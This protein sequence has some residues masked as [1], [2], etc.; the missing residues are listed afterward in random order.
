MAKKL[1]DLQ[2]DILFESLGKIFD[3]S[4]HFDEIVHWVLVRTINEMM[5]NEEYSTEMIKGEFK[6]ALI[7][8]LK[9]KKEDI[10]KEIKIVTNTK[11]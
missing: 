1:R 11:D 6:R 2:E 9:M 3:L 10:N 8:A 7:E 4:I 5:I